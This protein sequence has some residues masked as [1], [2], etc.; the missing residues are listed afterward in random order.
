NRYGAVQRATQ[1]Y[2]G[3]YVNSSGWTPPPY[4][5]ANAVKAMLEYTATKLRD[6]N[7]LVY[8]ALTQGA[9]E[10]NGEGALYLAYFTDTSQAVGSQWLTYPIVPSTVF[11]GT[12]KVAWNQSIIWGT[13]VA[14]GAALMDVNQAAWA[15]NI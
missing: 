8:D 13:T 12:E 4:P 3:R 14:S 6:G 11:G 10:V 9:G 15:Q 7:G 5:T 1:Q 2:G